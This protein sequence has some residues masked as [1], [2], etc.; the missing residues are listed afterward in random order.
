MWLYVAAAVS[1]CDCALALRYSMALFTSGGRS[2]TWRPVFR[3]RAVN[4]V[5]FRELGEECGADLCHALANGVHGRAGLLVISALGHSAPLS[6]MSR[7]LSDFR[8]LSEPS[9]QNPLLGESILSGFSLP[10]TR[11]PFGKMLVSVP[12]S[13]IYGQ[14]NDDFVQLYRITVS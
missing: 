13:T 2:H 12:P 3:R 9:S 7:T 4:R 1:A 14:K 6:G 5:Q 8:M 10:S 11:I